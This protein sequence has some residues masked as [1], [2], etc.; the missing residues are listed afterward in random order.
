MGRDAPHGPMAG[1]GGDPIPLRAWPCAAAALAAAGAA[2]AGGA[3]EVTTPMVVEVSPRVVTRCW[4]A[5]M[6]SAAAPGLT[7]PAATACGSKA[8]ALGKPVVAS[9]PTLAVPIMSDPRLDTS[10][11]S[12]GWPAMPPLLLGLEGSPRTPGAKA[13]TR[14]AAVTGYGCCCGALDAHCVAC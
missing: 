12:E 3:A 11:G 14:C 1:R 10:K 13:C 6:R 2:A 4:S 9:V 7:R 8:N 5:C